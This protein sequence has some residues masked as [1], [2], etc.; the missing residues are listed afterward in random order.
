MSSEP[1][2]EA[3][4][5]PLPHVGVAQSASSLHAAALHQLRDA[6]ALIATGK[7]SSN[8]R[9]ELLSDVAFLRQHIL[10]LQHHANL[11][12]PVLGLPDEIIREI[13]VILGHI[14]PPTVPHCDGSTKSPSLGWVLLSHVCKRFRDVLLD[15]HTLWAQVVSVFPSAHHELLRRAGARPISLLIP[16][17]TCSHTPSR[18]QFMV[19]HLQR[20]REIVV[21]RC[22]DTD[23]DT[24]RLDFA[25]FSGKELPHLQKLDLSLST[26]HARLV[27][28][29][30]FEFPAMVSPQLHTLRLDSIYVP[31]NAATLTHLELIR[32]SYAQPLPSASQ[33]LD[34]LRSCRKLQI[35]DLR[36]WVPEGLTIAQHA[37]VSLPSLQRLDVSE[38]DEKCLVLDSHLS[39]P[40]HTA[41]EYMTPMGSLSSP[42]LSNYTA[43]LE[44]HL[45][46][47][48]K[49]C[50]RGH[51]LSADNIDGA[52]RMH[53][54]L[55]PVSIPAM[56]LPPEP[57][58]L[59][60]SFNLQAPL[61]F[62]TLF[63]HVACICAGSVRLLDFC[64]MAPCPS[65]EDWR[66]MLQPLSRAQVID[67][68]NTTHTLL[69]ALAIGA[70]ADSPAPILPALC[71][72]AISELKFD[73]DFSTTDFIRMLLS[74]M[75]AGIPLKS[76]TIMKLDMDDSEAQ[77][78]FVPRLR[79]IVPDVDCRFL[80]ANKAKS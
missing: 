44:R 22:Q 40:P 51:M 32:T 9:D 39:L 35:L 8:L 69:S 24:V 6:Q 12:V 30:A 2:S 21:A 14:W 25:V 13:A 77:R 17:H 54:S 19:D 50:D 41:T 53:I 63:A 59:S 72:I 76:L 47:R 1:S 5:H 58:F 66:A 70:A 16:G 27:S 31:F 18:V 34:I 48:L 60:V 7:A 68:D 4:Q 11:C 15:H 38:K 33:F 20:C 78:T 71:E 10:Q 29:L 42:I 65:A 52:S 56:D 73:A 45:R 28:D 23:A 49:E 61:T 57:V 36:Y 43:F 37:S 74:R 80:Q 26:H 64:C 3:P 67:T 75:R 79:A 55:T 62:K 46:T